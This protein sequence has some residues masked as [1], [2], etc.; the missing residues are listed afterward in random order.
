MELDISD[1][2]RSAIPKWEG[3]PIMLTVKVHSKLLLDAANAI[4]MLT[5]AVGDLAEQLRREKN[6]HDG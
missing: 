5:Q 6:A 3:K 1:R 4:D 2:L